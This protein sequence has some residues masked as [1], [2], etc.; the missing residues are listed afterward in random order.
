MSDDGAAAYA[1]PKQKSKKRCMW[2]TIAILALLLL[3]FMITTIVLAC[4]GGSGGSAA[5][6]QQKIAAAL[7]LSSHMAPG[8][9]AEARAL[10]KAL[11]ISKDMGNTDL[12]MAPLSQTVTAIAKSSYWPFDIRGF[13][14]RVEAVDFSP[15]G[16]LL[17]AGSADETIKIT[18]IVTERRSLLPVPTEATTIDCNALVDVVAWSPSGNYLAAACNGIDS[19]GNRY[20]RVKV[21]SVQVP[22]DAIENGKFDLLFEMEHS[23]RVQTLAWS[24]NSTYLAAGDNAGLLKVGLRGVFGS[25][26]PPADFL[27]YHPAPH[28]CLSVV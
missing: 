19:K 9:T 23:E 25:D 20:G 8:N 15:D 17:A 27:R 12:V 10:A 7:I 11:E 4:R 18:P 21:W 16:R 14:S 6:K 3:I 22:V 24:H 13:K 28:S 5:G 26:P 1:S 2:I